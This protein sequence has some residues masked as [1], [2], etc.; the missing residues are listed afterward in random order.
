[1]VKVNVYLDFNCSSCEEYLEAM[2]FWTDFYSFDYTLNKLDDDPVKMFE[3]VRGYRKEGIPVEYF[4][5]VIIDNDKLEKK[6]FK[7]GILNKIEIER[8]MT[9]HGR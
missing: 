6:E 3:D 9:K 2:E 1:M 7:S 5:F 8:L 4:P